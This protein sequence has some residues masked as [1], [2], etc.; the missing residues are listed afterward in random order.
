MAHATLMTRTMV[1]L[2]AYLIGVEVHLSPGL[3]RFSIV[4]MPEASIQES[5]ERVRSALMNG[6]FA[7]PQQRITIN[8]TPA[9]LPKTGTHFDLPIALAIL[10]ASGQ[11]DASQHSTAYEFVGE[12]SLT[13]RL[14]A[15]P[16]IMQKALACTQD[17][18]R[19]MLPAMQVH[20]VHCI[21]NIEAYGAPSL[22]A[23]VNHLNGHTRI[24]VITKQSMPNMCHS[25]INPYANIQGQTLAKRAL[26][27]AAAGGHHYLMVGPPGTGKSMLADIMPQLLPHM[28]DMATITAT[29]IRQ[30]D[31][32]DAP[33]S[34]QR[35][36][37]HPHHS[38]S[39]AGLLGGG[40]P[41]RPG[42]ITRAHLG[43]LFLDEL[44]EFSRNTLEQFREP[45]ET[46]HI[47][48]ARAGH[49]IQYPSRFQLLAAMNP[50]P[51]GMLGHPT[52]PC[53]CTP[54]QRQRYLAKLSQPLLE[55]FGLCVQ[56]HPPTHT[57]QTHPADVFSIT[58]IHSAYQTQMTRQSCP[59]QQLPPGQLY[60]MLHWDAA[61]TQIFQD[62]AQKHQWSK[63]T[64]HQT[65]K[66]ARTLADLEQKIGVTTAHL[67]EAQQ[68]LCVHVFERYR[69]N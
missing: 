6:Q 68:Y 31:Q 59:N 51:C 3:P 2:E 55:R 53:H 23:V 46:G 21:P 42:E 66:I 58:S 18:H 32:P 43:V 20:H 16:A 9:K 22:R 45:L 17:Q 14:L 48:I 69:L 50:C 56:L 61:T 33:I 39:A 64:Q 5:K 60:A 52:K 10:M 35:P 34:R 12:L 7:M 36:F 38:I 62:M 57:N 28:D 54:A 40:N 44:T 15:V 19:M 29:I 24:P 25:D 47:V 8:L 49:C 4:G 65:L 27:I 37:R 30:L 1:G 13:G 67:T 11:L 63:R 41:P 26:G